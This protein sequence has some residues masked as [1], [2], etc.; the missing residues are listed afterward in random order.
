MADCTGAA[1]DEYHLASERS[2]REPIRSRLADGQAA[3]GG[4]CG[5]PECCAEVE[6]RLV[7][8]VYS[9]SF[10]KNDVFLRGAVGAAPRRLPEP[11]SFADSGRIDLRADCVD[12]ARPV[13]V[14]DDLG[15][16]DAAASA[17]ASQLPVGRIHA[18]DGDAHPHVALAGL[19]KRSLD[20]AEHL[21][22]AEL[23]VDHC[24]HRSDN[25]TNRLPSAAIRW[26]S[27]TSSGDVS[28]TRSRPW[29][30]I[31]SNPQGW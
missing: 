4:K 22:A 30:D 11:H 6:R 26:A 29:W 24:P 31:A 13:L 7:G 10:G 5:D 2:R 23:R 25:A 19:G 17:P 28:S 1:R 8:E 12:D 18:R 15:K 14:R 20:K 3:V 9:L 21:R 16:G 27:A